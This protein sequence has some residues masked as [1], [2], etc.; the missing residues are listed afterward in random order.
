M[1]IIKNTFNRLRHFNKKSEQIFEMYGLQ[2]PEEIY[3][4]TARFQDLNAKLILESVY[5]YRKAIDFDPYPES[6]IEQKEKN[7]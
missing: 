6:Y 5:E 4:L 3:L 2:N 1:F 7:E